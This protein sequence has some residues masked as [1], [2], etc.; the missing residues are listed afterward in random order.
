MQ[1][2]KSRRMHKNKKNSSQD[3]YQE[4]SQDKYQDNYYQDKYQDSSQDK[5]QDNYQDKYSIKIAYL[6]SCPPSYA[7]AAA[8]SAAVSG[9]GAAYAGAKLSGVG[10]VRGLRQSAA[11]RPGGLMGRP[12]QAAAGTYHHLTGAGLQ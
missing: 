10:A 6:L 11:S 7:G 5:Y 3:K 12:V 9:P 8:A 4:S 1:N 2:K